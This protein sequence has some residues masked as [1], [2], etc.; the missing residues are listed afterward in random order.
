MPFVTVNAFVKVTT[1][2][3][4]VTVTLLAPAAAVLLIF[5]TAVADVEEL[6]VSEATVIPAP[7]VATEVP[8]TK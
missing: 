4:V 2:V 5:R 3:P 8:C 6:T 7:K 1:S